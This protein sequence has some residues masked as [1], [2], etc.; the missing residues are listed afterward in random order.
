MIFLVRDAVRSCA[1]TCI[2]LL[3]SPFASNDEHE[4]SGGGLVTRAL[5]SQQLWLI[6]TYLGLLFL[7]TRAYV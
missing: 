5:R 4:G 1:P 6:V 3:K 2:A 7:L